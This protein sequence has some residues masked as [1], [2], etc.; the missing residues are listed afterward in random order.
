M[1]RL[2]IIFI[3]GFH[4]VEGFE[5]WDIATAFTKAEFKALPSCIACQ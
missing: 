5:Q 2:W 4:T 3:Q 1:Q